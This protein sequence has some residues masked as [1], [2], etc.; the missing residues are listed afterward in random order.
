MKGQDYARY[1]ARVNL[2]REV[3]GRVTIGGQTQ[4]SHFDRSAGS[5]LYH[6][7]RGVYPLADIFDAEGKMITSRPGN[8][9]QL[10]NYSLN[11]E[12][13]GRLRKKD[14]FPGSYYVEVKLS[15]NVSCR[16]N[17][18]IDIGAYCDHNFFGALSSDRAGSPARAEN[19]GDNRRMYTWENLLFYCDAF[20]NRHPV[21]LRCSSRY[22]RKRWNLLR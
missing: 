22:G 8:D 4:F 14:R 21:A 10:W 17:A 19:K 12:N 2:D 6:D 18:S 1:S 11:L 20:N 5:N 15:L 3:N 16:T 7:S 9:P 13:T